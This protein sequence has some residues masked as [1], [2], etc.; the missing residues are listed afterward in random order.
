[1]NLIGQYRKHGSTGIFGVWLLIHCSLGFAEP[2]S[3]EQAVNMALENHLDI[4]IAVNTETQAKYALQAAEGSLGI[5]VDASNT[6]YLKQIHY[7]ATTNSSEI[8]VSLP[9]YS[10]GKNEGNIAIAKI[11]LTTADLDLQK[12]KQDVKLNTLAAYFD[13]INYRETIA[14]AQETV[15]NYSKHLENVKAQYSA[16]NVPKSDVLSSEVQLVDAQQTLMQD[17]NKYEV[18]VNKLK[19]L[20]RWNRPDQPELVSGFQHNPVKQSM[21]DCVAYAKSNHPTLRKYR[22]DIDEAEKSVEVAGADKKPSISLT[23]ATGWGSSVLPTDDSKDVYVGVTTS[24]NLFDSQITNAN[25]NKAKSK[26]DSAR[27]DLTSE[28]DS[29]VL[30]VKEYYLDLKEAEKRMETTQVAIKQAEENYFIAEA[31]Y[32]I[33]EGILLDVID[34]QLSLTTAKE[35]YITAQYDYDTY[36]AK[37]ENAM[38]MD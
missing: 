17:K 27:L 24:W 35:N 25:I 8:A 18:A 28:E 22:L 10:G 1:M 14:V 21:D 30:S 15:D 34:A 37:L 6:F 13:I 12:T 38:G 9:L 33:G 23:A 16:G 26:V 36:K 32:R 19:N 7:S 2:L 11:D 4:K 5:S 20:I 31:K 3:L 29:V